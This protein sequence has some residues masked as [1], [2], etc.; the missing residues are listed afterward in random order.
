[1]TRSNDDKRFEQLLQRMDPKS[2]LLRTWPLKGGVSAQ[3]TALEIA[4][5][6]GHTK[7]VIVRQHGP[8]DLTRNPHIA[9]D[10]FV[11]LQRLHAAGL[12]TPTPYYFQQS[13]DVFSTPA[14]VLEYIEGTPA[15]TLS[16]DQIREFALHLAM[17]HTLDCAALD[18]GFLP[19]H[20]DLLAR[21]LKER[22]AT[23]EQ[24]YNEQRI[25]HVLQ[26]IG[27][28]PQRNPSVLLHGD[29]WPGNTLW[30]DRKLVAIIDWEDAAIGDPLADVANSRLEVLWAGGIDA[31]NNFTQRYRSL[32]PIDVMNLTY[33]DLCAALRPAR[34][35]A[36]WGLDV[37]IER[38]MRDGLQTFIQQAIAKLM[39]Q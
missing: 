17:I 16:N 1:M 5:P 34:K 13:D 39:G 11:L 22:P 2:T 6:D 33:Y 28:V 27:P 10:E 19:N 7:K 29:Y 24:S 3:V 14:I 30:K 25:R 32:M 8:M 38:T 18:L 4:D 12:A 23:A 26:C 37:Q 36:S 20:A 31:M 15:A 21:T 9:A 35:M